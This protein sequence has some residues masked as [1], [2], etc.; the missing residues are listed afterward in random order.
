MCARQKERV[1]ATMSFKKHLKRCLPDR[2]IHVTREVERCF[3]V[4]L[5]RPTHFNL[6]F[7]DMFPRAPSKAVGAV[8]RLRYQRALLDWIKRAQDH[9]TGGVPGY[10][11]LATGWSAD[12]PETT[13][14]IVNTLLD[15]AS[16]LN[17]DDLVSRAERLADWE[18]KV[19]L[20]NGSWQS[21]F[22]DQ[23]PVPAVFNTGQVLQGMVAA[24]SRFK[25]PEYLESAVR[26]GRWLV[27]VQDP[28]GA[29]RKHTY[30]EFANTYNSRVA[31]PLLSLWI[32]TGETA[33]RDSAIRYLEWARTRQHD[34]GWLEDCTL[35]PQEPPL[36]HTLAYASE[37]FVESGVILGDER[38]IDA[39]RAIADKLLAYQNQHGCLAGTYDIGWQADKSFNCLTGSAQ[40]GR[41]WGRLYEITAQ[42]DYAVGVST[43]NDYLCN[44]IHLDCK[45]D[46]I[47]GGL[48]GS[49]PIWGH[50]MTY[51]FPNWAPKFALDSFFK[52]DEIRAQAF[53]SEVRPCTN[54]NE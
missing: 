4:R 11:C 8:Q 19:Q 6:W 39:G 31:W 50:Y 29:W 33:F 26:A 2:A 18:L 45:D 7:R 30:R 37:G 53:T 9:G 21:G 12:Y 5:Y 1:V 40:M 54:V 49:H 47:R 48:K 52:E 42:D 14:Y 36:T 28:D 32:S 10:Y 38:W 13:G 20:N 24:A 22:V 44:L 16:H 23:Q 46:A 17:D 41:V 43:T 34:S 27:E 51:R 3:D 25:K 35:E 15:G